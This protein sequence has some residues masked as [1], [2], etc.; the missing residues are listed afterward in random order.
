MIKLENAEVLGWEHA[1]RGMRNP[2]NSWEKSDGGICMDTL[3]CHSCEKNRTTECNVTV[4]HG[5]YIIG[6]N[7]LDLMKRL[8]NAGY[9]TRKNAIEACK[10]FVQN[11]Y[12]ESYL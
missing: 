7:D 8:R 6:P 3:A 10:Q 4:K 1:I 9:D 11:A 5:D 2:L 12:G